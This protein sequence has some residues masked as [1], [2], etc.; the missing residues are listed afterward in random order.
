MKTIIFL[1]LNASEKPK[2]HGVL[3]TSLNGVIASILFCCDGHQNPVLLEVAF[4]AEQSFIMAF[5][6]LLKSTL[7]F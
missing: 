7:L 1:K 2:L 3:E 5:Y 6:Y 4:G